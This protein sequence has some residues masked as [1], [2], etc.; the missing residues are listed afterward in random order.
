MRVFAPTAFRYPALT[1]RDYPYGLQDIGDDSLARTLLA[2]QLVVADDPS[3]Q[4]NA[5]DRPLNQFPIATAA[6]LTALVSQA[7]ILAL[8]AGNNSTAGMDLVLCLGMLLLRD[9]SSEH[10]REISYCPDLVAHPCQQPCWKF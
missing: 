5:G 9:I 4:V 8:V 7:G 3:D 2:A 6:A 10:H 1:G